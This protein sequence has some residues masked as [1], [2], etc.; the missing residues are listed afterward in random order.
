[1]IIPD[2]E[3]PQDQAEANVVPLKKDVLD[4][5]QVRLWLSRCRTAN[6]FHRG[7]LMP[8]YRTAKDRYNGEMTATL[9]KKGKAEHQE[10]NFLFKDVEDFNSSIYHKNPEINLTCRNTQDDNEIRN[11]ENLEQLVNDDISDDKTLKPKIRAGLVD[12]NL[13]ALGVFY[14]D[15]DYRAENSVDENGMP[16]IDPIAEKIMLVKL[17]PENLI[18]PPFQTL[19]NYQESPYLGYVDIV[20]LETLKSDPTLNQDVISKIKGQNYSE[21]LD[22]DKEEFKGK[23]LEKDDLLY[24]KVYVCFIRGGDKMPL[25][26]LVLADQSGLTEPL[27]YEDYDKGHGPEDRGYPI[28]I[29]ALND[30]LGFVPPSEA[31]NVEPIIRQLDYIWAKMISHVRGSKTRSFAKVGKDGLKKTDIFKWVKNEDLE[32]IGVNNLAPG[33]DLR[34]LIMQME[35]KPLAND[36]AALFD[37]GKR[38]FD[39]LSRQPAFA[40][41]AVLEQK[42]TATEAN[43]IQQEDKGLNAYKIDKF[44]DFLKALFYDWAKLRQKNFQ[45]S[46]SI[47]VEQK[48]TGMLEPREVS[49]NELTGK[50]NADIDVESFVKPNRE[51]RR[52]II[53]ESL[54]DSTIFIPLLKEQGLKLNGKR[55][56]SDY[57]QNAEMRNPDELFMKIPVR[58]MDQQVTD[59]VYKQVPFNAEELGGDVQ[60]ELQ[61]LMQIFGDDQMMQVY[62]RSSPGISLPNG[63]LAEFARGL[64]TMMT[65]M[66]P[67]Q[68]APSM[69]APED[70]KAE[71][72]MMS[73]AN[74]V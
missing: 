18:R 2:A 16:S 63:P 74:A 55:I 68:P 44:K 15:Y 60:K 46:K 24:A 11:I 6:K 67:G 13:S 72:G 34:S 23:E 54:Q 38:L 71:A 9:G 61:R 7:E 28:H 65:K 73:N 22:V 27:A 17:R 20:S 69:P 52:R 64:E 57:L 1:M 56:V 48:Q 35:D 33:I 12:E 4:S 59:F 25:K 10:L 31:W 43:A 5:D 42:K 50:F 62:E 8:R 14:I 41:S 70:V 53:K 51:L 39:Q 37:L 45:G 36:H 21:L 29:L 32:I 49:A 40:Q 19:Y 58:T 47:T 66:K 3:Q 30:A 26:R